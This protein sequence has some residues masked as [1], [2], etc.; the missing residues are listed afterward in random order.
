[1]Q[2]PAYNISEVE[3]HLQL[4]CHLSLITKF[5]SV[6]PEETIAL[7]QRMSRTDCVG[8]IILLSMILT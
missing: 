2:Y 5:L 1:M 8:F 6:G 4:F 7:K 3:K